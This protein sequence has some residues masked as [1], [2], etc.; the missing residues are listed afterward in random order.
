VASLALAGRL[1]SVVREFPVLGA[2]DAAVWIG[3]A[4]D[5]LVVSAADAVRLPN[6]LGI[7][8][9]SADRPFGPVRP[10]EPAAVG[11]GEIRLSSMVVKAVRWWDPVPALPRV[12]P[13]TVG[14]AVASLDGTVLRPDDGGFAAALAR[15]DER[16]AVAAARRS[17]GFGDGLTPASDDLLAGTVAG[18]LH[19]SRCLGDPGGGGLLGRIAG[20]VLDHAAG[21]TTALSAVLLG[22]A[23]RGEVALPAGRVLAALAGRGDPVRSAG[24]LMAVGHSSGPALAAGLAAGARASLERRT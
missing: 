9:P 22:H 20:P 3:E 13:A 11:G 19:I 16:T 14:R 21:A 18:F 7:A 1:E 12:G 24:D 8:V 15:G 6:G 10:G 2:T 5:V 17:I 4:Q 23:F